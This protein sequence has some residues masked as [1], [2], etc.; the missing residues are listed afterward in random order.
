MILLVIVVAEFNVPMISRELLVKVLEIDLTVIDDV[1]L[2]GL[3]G[4]V[5]LIVLLDLCL[6][7]FDDLLL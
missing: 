3:V 7:L 5:E 4:V 2:V 1:I 6:G